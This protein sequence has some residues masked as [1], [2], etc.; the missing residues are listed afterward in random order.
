MVAITTSRGSAGTAASKRPATRTGHSTSAVTSSSSARRSARV[1]R[2]AAARR[3]HAGADRARGARRNPRPPWRG[4]ARLGSA[5][6]D[7]R[8][9]R[10]AAHEIGGRRWC[11]R[12][13]SPSTSQRNDLVAEQQ[14]HPVHRPHELG[15]PA[16]QRMRLAIG[17]AAT[18][19]DDEPAEQARPSRRRVRCRDTPAMQP[20]SVVSVSSSAD[21]DAAASGEGDRGLGR[22]AGGIEGIGERRPAPLDLP[23]GRTLGAA[24]P[25][26][27][28]GA[29]ASRSARTTP[30]AMPAPSR[31][32]CRCLGE[33]GRQAVGSA[34]G[35]SSSVPS[36]N[37]RSRVLIR[38]PAAL[39]RSFS[40]GKPERFAAVAVPSATPR[41]SWRTRRMKRWRS[42]T[43]T[44]CR[45]SSR[46]KACD[47]LTI[48][49]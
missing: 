35:G 43:E 11:G 8:H 21:R 42:V 18:A 31:L 27:P 48:C 12:T 19:C 26:A 46:L 29:A 20:L 34:R 10:R 49:S 25:R 15:A 45:A 16:P 41:A 32:F 13:R 2:P 17:S 5:S 38:P 7:R 14:H 24:I 30:C 28:R 37:N 6:A 47:A 22:R 40:S 9:D 33:R 4:A 36:S 1:R 3:E 23:V 44:A 39:G